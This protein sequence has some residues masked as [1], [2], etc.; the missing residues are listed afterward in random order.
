MD[1]KT[2]IKIVLGITVVVMLFHLCIILRIIPYEIT[3]GGR[4]K[5]ESEMYAFETVSIIINLFLGLIL[6]IKAGYLKPF[7][8]LKIVNMILWAFF[9]LFALNTIGNLLAKTIFEKFLAILT[10]T[11]SV[12]IWKI[13]VK[14]KEP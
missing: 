2:P 6:L 3:W 1:A 13:L 8:P 11:L 5:N 12:L 7:I 14:R 9:G 10:L 4:L